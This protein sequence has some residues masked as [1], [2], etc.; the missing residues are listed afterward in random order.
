MFMKFEAKHEIVSDQTNVT[1]STVTNG[2]PHMVGVLLLRRHQWDHIQQIILAGVNALGGKVVGDV[3][4]EVT[5]SV[6][7]QIK[8]IKNG[9]TSS[10]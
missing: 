3:K 8:L 1:V 5:V 9:A 6:P 4:R 10:E 2:N 7:D